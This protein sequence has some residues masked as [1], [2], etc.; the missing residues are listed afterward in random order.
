[1]SLNKTKYLPRVLT[2]LREIWPR[3]VMTKKML[4]GK[5]NHNINTQK[6]T[7]TNTTNSSMKKDNMNI[8][9]KRTAWKRSVK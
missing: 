4:T 9:Y 3:P 8:K 2:I 7:M 1:M 5:F 6:A